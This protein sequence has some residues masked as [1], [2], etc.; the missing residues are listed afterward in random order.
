MHRIEA[1]GLT[2]SCWAKVRFL[3]HGRHPSFPPGLTFRAISSKE[4]RLAALYPRVNLLLTS[5]LSVALSSDYRS[6][7]SVPHRAVE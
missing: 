3:V 4:V 6:G 5:S 2:I 1:A 7:A